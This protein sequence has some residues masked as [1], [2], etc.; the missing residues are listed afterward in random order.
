MKF[1][2][3]N[4]TRLAKKDIEVH[5]KGIN[6]L[7]F[8]VIDD[9]V[10]GYADIK[11]NLYYLRTVDYS[12]LSLNPENP[13]TSLAIDQDDNSYSETNIKCYFTSNPHAKKELNN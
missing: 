13:Y 8:I 6:K 7:F 3:L 10:V 4:I 11:E 1:N 9:E 12:A 5:L 2:L